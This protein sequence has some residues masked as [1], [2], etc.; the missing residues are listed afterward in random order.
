MKSPS[1]PRGAMMTR[2]SC[3][4][5]ARHV[6]EGGTDGAALPSVWRA[7]APGCER[8]RDHRCGR[9]GGT[10]SGFKWGAGRGVS[11]GWAGGGAWAEGGCASRLGSPPF[12]PR[13]AGCS[14]GGLMT[15]G[16]P[17]G[18]A[19]GGGASSVCVA[20][21]D[22]RIIDHSDTGG[23][24]STW[25]IAFRNKGIG[26]DWGERVTCGD[27]GVLAWES[28]RARDWST[29]RGEANWNALMRHSNRGR[30]SARGDR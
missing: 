19:G 16:G 3:S 18:R 2:A 24:L 4:R 22:V 5:A 13:G 7:T 9:T 21:G 28:C 20:A 6:T 25:G 23:N 11:P 12:V 8:R 1:R 10:A 14:L 30:R 29:K 17:R 26:V 15:R 27:G